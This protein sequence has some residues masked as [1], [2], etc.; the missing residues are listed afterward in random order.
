MGLRIERVRFVKRIQYFMCL[1]VCVGGLV[2][3]L[4]VQY[5]HLW[6]LKVNIMCQRGRGNVPDKSRGCL[7]KSSGHFS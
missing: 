5:K 2:E 4:K 3:R 6:R 7:L 1:C